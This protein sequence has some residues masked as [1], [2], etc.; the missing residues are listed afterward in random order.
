MSEE[1][2]SKKNYF[3]W[4]FKEEKKRRKGFLWYFIALIIIIFLLILSI[5]QRNWL[6]IIII[7]LSVFLYISFEKQ[8]P[9]KYKVKIS[10]RGV[11]IGRKLYPFIHLKG[12]GFQQE[13]NRK[14]L[15][16]ETDKIGGRFVKFPLRVDEDELADLLIK[17][18]PEKEYEDSLLDRIG[19][20]IKF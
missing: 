9:Q 16:L 10:G 2:T 1:K 19:E 4:T 12:F 20:I 8:K 14:F 17:H 7:A 15:I 5:K 18:I 11:E 13:E 3:S 6:F